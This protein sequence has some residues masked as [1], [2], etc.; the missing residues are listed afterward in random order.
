LYLSYNGTFILPDFV[1]FV[2]QI[3]KL[4]TNQLYLLKQC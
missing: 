2:Q 4:D 3:F 1:I